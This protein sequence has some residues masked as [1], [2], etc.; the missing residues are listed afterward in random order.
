[1][2]ELNDPPVEMEDEES[3]S[4]LRELLE[5][6]DEAGFSVSEVWQAMQVIRPPMPVEQSVTVAYVMGNSV[7]YSWHHSMMNMIGW[8]QNNA[9]HLQDGGFIAIRYG[10]DGLVA[11]RNQAVQIFLDE[12]PADWLFWI[13]TDMGFKPNT[14]DRLLAAADPVE[15]P[16][17]GGLCFSNKE[18]G[19]DGLGGWRTEAVPTV[20]DWAHEPDPAGGPDRMG[21]AVRWQ[22]QPNSLVQCAGTGSA[23]V[24]IH[25][26]VFER[27]ASGAGDI[28]PYGPHWY[29]RAYNASMRQETSE[30]LSFCMRAWSLGIPVHILTGV[31]TTHEKTV[32][33]S[34]DHYWAQQARLPRKRG[35]AVDRQAT[36]GGP[37]AAG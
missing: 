9:R 6:L 7:S 26:S 10:T 24:L 28:P 3:T 22:Y 4:Q 5:R 27:I 35:Q 8:D 33:L 21:F 12:K 34:E 18:T 17:V 29:D 19:E 13:D 2:T 30:D 36:E 1:M 16:I 32:W 23:C 15:R 37:S 14:V 11:S 31:R 20:Y 25:R